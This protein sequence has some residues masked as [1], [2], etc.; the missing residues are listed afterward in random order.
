MARIVRGMVL[1]LKEKE[2][3]EAARALGSSNS[4]ILF[5]HL[6][7]NCT[8]QIIV[9]ITLSVAAAILTESAL[10]FLGFGVQSAVTPTWGNLLEQAKGQI[11]TSPHLV[12][13]PGLAIVIGGAVRELPG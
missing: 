7:P 9:N 8:G 12:W 1:S 3:V 11:R 6:L 10:S 13:F 4:R 5:R 2:F